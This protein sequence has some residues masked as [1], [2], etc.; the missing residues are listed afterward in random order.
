M[1]SSHPPL[2]RP[3]SPPVSRWA[4][5]RRRTVL[6]LG[7]GLGALALAAVTGLAAPTSAAAQSAYP[8]RPVTLVVPFPAGGSTDLVAR[9]IAS[10]MTGVLGQQIVVENRGGAGGNLGSAAVARAE[11]DGYTI[12][13][14]TVA[15]H[16][17][18]PALQKKMPYDAVKDFAPVSLLALIPN[19]LVVS[20]NFPAKNAKVAG[21]TDRSLASGLSRP[22]APSSRS[23]R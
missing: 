12:L 8:S 18:N 20:N 5:L 17:L 16:A 7:A 3:P 13:M 6:G 22:F 19:V 23:S 1:Q 11:P 4:A 14:G 2:S 15:T 9:L 10:R 21:G